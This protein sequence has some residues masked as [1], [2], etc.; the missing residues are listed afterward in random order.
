MEIVG[1][2]SVFAFFGCPIADLRQRFVGIWVGVDVG[3]SAGSGG[4]LARGGCRPKRSGF[5]FRG[6]LKS[7][8][9]DTLRRDWRFHAGYGL[10]LGLD[11]TYSYCWIRFSAG[12][13]DLL[14]PDLVT[15]AC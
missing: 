8:N 4:F 10:L 13:S 6:R 14:C 15:L 9:R 7:R 1:L 5:G 3:I 11:P 2:L 12:I